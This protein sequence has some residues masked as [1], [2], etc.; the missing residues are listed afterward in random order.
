MAQGPLPCLPLQHTGPGE[1][2]GFQGRVGRGGGVTKKCPSLVSSLARTQG[3][4]AQA[5]PASV[6][7]SGGWLLSDKERGAAC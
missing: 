6:G 5:V 2:F 1:K 3:E 4:P 7:V